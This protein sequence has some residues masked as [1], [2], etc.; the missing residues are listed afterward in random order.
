MATKIS[1][2]PAPR[3]VQALHNPLLLNMIKSMNI[4]RYTT[5]IKLLISWFWGD[6][7]QMDLA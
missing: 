6:Q 4:M 3:D 5:L 2:H 1:P 7:K